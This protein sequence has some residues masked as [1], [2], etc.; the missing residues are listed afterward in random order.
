[1]APKKNKISRYKTCLN[2]RE[3]VFSGLIRV[4][5]G[6]SQ[7]ARYWALE[8]D[9]SGV[10]DVHVT[11]VSHKRLRALWRLLRPIADR[12]IYQHENLR[13][14]HSSLALSPF[15]DADVGSD[16]LNKAISKYALRG[17]A[18]LIAVINSMREYLNSHREA[19]SDDRKELLKIACEQLNLSI[20]SLKKI[21]IRQ[22]GWAILK[23]GLVRSY[24]RVRAAY[25]SIPLAQDSEEANH[26]WRK[27]L[28]DLTYQVEII[29]GIWPKGLSRFLKKLRR[30]SR[31]TGDYNDLMVLRS[32]AAAIMCEPGYENLN[33]QAFLQWTDE[34]AESLQHKALLS[35]GQALEKSE[36]KWIE[37][38][39]KKWRSWR[40][41]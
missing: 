27:A 9:E 34:R 13:L 19:I 41:R 7:K 35:A 18:D 37:K 17:N 30:L 38:L 24:R 26:E 16:F 28:K 2:R 36:V 33:W 6:Y 39:E 15:R 3:A 4:G 14:R 12:K 25:H 40:R 22:R 11:R 20:K 8:K 21:E 32:N 10:E 23:P 29:I 1:M 31:L 5:Y